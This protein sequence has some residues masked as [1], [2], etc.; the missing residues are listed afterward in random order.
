MASSDAFKVSSLKDKV[1]LI[2]GASSGIGAGAAVL[3]A[4]LGARLALN[5]RDVNNLAKVARECED[6]G[7]CKPLLVP[8]DL[9]DE[10]T[11]KKT[12]EQ[13][14]A[15]FGRL[16]VLVNSAGILAMGSIETTDLAQYDKVMNV[17]VRSV[18]HLT[19]LC[20]P[21]LIKTKGSIVNVSSVNGQ[22]S[23]PGVLAYCMSKSAIDQFTRCVAL[24]LASKQVRVNSVCPG[25]IITEVHKRAGLDEEQ[26]KQ[27][28]E[29]CKV[30][31][32]L[33][34]PGEVEEVAHAIAFLASDAATYI[35]G[36]NLPVD[37]GRH[38]MCPR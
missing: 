14:V 10:T 27:F 30:T 35:T 5:G 18:Y 32:A 37:G 13:T 15:H 21:H 38:A 4:R 19:Y 31:H 8:G 25:V 2:T 29:K 17:N 9:T 24:E 36:V 11:V 1:T 6:C 34:R 3:F 22:R 12:V 20:V 26:Y 23:F 16:D 7:A 28:L 33:G